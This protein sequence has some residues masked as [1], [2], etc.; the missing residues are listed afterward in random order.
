MSNFNQYLEAVKKPKMIDY[1]SEH[2]VHFDMVS[3]NKSGNYVGRKQFFYHHGQSSD[4]IADK[5]KNIPGITV[6]DDGEHNAAF[7]GGASVAKSSHFWVEFKFEESKQ[8]NE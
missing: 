5:M 3:K 7:R 1:L 4:K 2:G 6:I 8:E